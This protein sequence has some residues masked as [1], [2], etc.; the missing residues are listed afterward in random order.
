[1]QSL[2]W[3]LKPE[4]WWSPL[5]GSL[6]AAV[7]WVSDSGTSFFY[8]DIALGLIVGSYLVFSIIVVPILFLCRKTVTWTTSKLVALGAALSGGPTIL[9]YFWLFID[10][11]FRGEAGTFVSDVFKLDWTPLWCFLVAGCC[12]SYTFAVIQSHGVDHAH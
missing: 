6:G 5:A 2:G 11:L 7:F 4:A 8:L 10:R 1:M 9:L 3:P 12:A